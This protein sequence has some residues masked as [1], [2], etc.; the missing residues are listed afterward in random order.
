MNLSVPIYQLKR[1]AKLLSRHDGVPL[2]EALNSIAKQEGF[3]SWSLLAARHA[4]SGPAAKILAALEI[5]DLV[6][7]GARPGHGKTLMGLE[8][9]VETI[10]SGNQAAFYS[11]E[12][13]ENELSEQFAALGAD[14][15]A[16][17]DM[18]TMDTSDDICADYIIEL[19]SNAPRGTVVVVDY[20]QLLDQNRARPVLATQISALK[21]FAETAGVIIVMIS[22]IDRSYDPIAKPL[23]DVSDVRLPNSLDLNLFTKTIFLNDGA[24]NL[25]AV[26]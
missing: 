25:Q 26:G 6:L 23:P 16:S 22:Q 3:Q 2:H 9:I 7:L 13:T 19:L 10:K 14:V 11:L 12:Y 24:A 5:G 15:T 8:L 20:L 21:S 17:G 1:Q 4:E 18:L